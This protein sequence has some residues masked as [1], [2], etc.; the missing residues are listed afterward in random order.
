[1]RAIDLDWS[2]IPNFS[3]EEFPD[4][5]LYYMDERIIYA[6]SDI[7]Q[8]SGCPILPS[9][10]TRAH[11]RHD[12]SGSR[13]STLNKTRLSDATDFF[14]AWEDAMEILLA[15]RNHPDIRGYGIYDSMMI[16]GAP[17]EKA[18]F[19][20]DTRPRGIVCWWGKG[21][22]PVNYVYMSPEELK[23]YLKKFLQKKG[24]KEED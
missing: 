2:K 15:I 17:G 12:N 24:I 8:K 5:V 19:H 9:P 10:V 4:N 13:H 16:S 23:E 21:R 6:L 22:D 18:M 7:R 3:K 1:M 20:I 14:C 11:V